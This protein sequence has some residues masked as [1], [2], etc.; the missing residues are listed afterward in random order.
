MAGRAVI[1]PEL[2]Q[3]TIAADHGGDESGTRRVAQ[4]VAPTKQIGISAFV[5]RTRTMS[6]LDDAEHDVV[7]PAVPGA[8]RASSRSSNALNSA[9]ENAW[10]QT[11]SNV[12]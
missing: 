12:A 7:A 5:W 11:L 2:R 4:G 9:N 10:L 6:P 1:Q 8:P 3:T